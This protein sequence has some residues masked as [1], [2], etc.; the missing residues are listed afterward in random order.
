MNTY[1]TKL[2][3]FLKNSKDINKKE[4]LIYLCINF[5]FL[6]I[7]IM[8]FLISFYPTLLGYPENMF[9]L[10][11]G[12]ILIA[13]WFLF[14]PILSRDAKDKVI[15]HAGYSSLALVALIITIY[16]WLVTVSTYNFIF[17]DIIIVL[18]SIPTIAYLLYLIINFFKLILLVLKKALKKIIPSY[19]EKHSGLLYVIESITSIFVAISTF[20][21]AFWGAITA[22]KTFI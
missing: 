10:Y 6:I 19:K 12:C 11:F 21:A 1:L 7:G 20:L 22:L 9:R 2:V 17:F 18:L 4:F 8:L 5:S 16:Y 15:S 3:T 13:I 14:L